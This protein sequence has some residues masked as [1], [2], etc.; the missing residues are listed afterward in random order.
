MSIPAKIRNNVLDFYLGKLA[1]IAIR[2]RQLLDIER[3]RA[4]IE[5]LVW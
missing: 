5:V 2:F 4:F 3:H 1:E